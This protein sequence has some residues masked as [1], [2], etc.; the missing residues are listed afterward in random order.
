MDSTSNYYINSSVQIF[1]NY[2]LLI[3][4]HFR[5]QWASD[6]EVYRPYLYKPKINV[7][8]QRTF[9]GQNYDNQHNELHERDSFLTINSILYKENPV[10]LS[11]NLSSSKEEY[12]FYATAHETVLSK[13][14]IGQTNFIKTLRLIFQ[15]LKLRFAH[16]V[17]TSSVPR[18][19]RLYR[20]TSGY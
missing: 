9:L 14:T 1:S 17:M 10:I 13:P 8:K 15:P 3:I 12:L 2:F 4:L 16:T 20:V 6:G 7:F 19:V 18:A 5:V 11:A